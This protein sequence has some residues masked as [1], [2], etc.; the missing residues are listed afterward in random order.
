MLLD[1]GDLPLALHVAALACEL[2]VPCVLDADTPAP[3]IEALLA[4]A[5]HPVISEPLARA[6]YGGAEAAVCALAS[7]G[8]ALPV[9]TRGAAGAV[10]FVDRAPRASAAFAIEPLDTTGAGDA[11]HAGIAHG[12]L[13]GLAGDE[14]LRTAHAVA[15]C[16]CLGL[17]AQAGLPDRAQLAAFLA[18]TPRRG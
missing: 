2:G 4:K 14:L 12:L 13:C 3:G 11:F 5:S 8:A 1:A 16:A 18:R 17:G 15:A 9:V 7:G 10:A 6:L